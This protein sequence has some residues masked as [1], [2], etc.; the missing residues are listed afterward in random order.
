[1]SWSIAIGLALF[2]IGIG[3]QVLFIAP[4]GFWDDVMKSHLPSVLGLP[5]AAI[6]A[7]VIVLVLRTVS[8]AIE[9]K[10]VG[11]ELKGAAGP[12]IMWV[13]CFLAMAWAIGHTWELKN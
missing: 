11:L 5:C 4:R 2:T 7:L 6:A 9:F 13:V 10:V 1:M 8:G 3:V 12:I